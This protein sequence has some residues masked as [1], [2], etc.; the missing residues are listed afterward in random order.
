MKS[1]NIIVLLVTILITHTACSSGMNPVSGDV[2]SQQ[3]NNATQYLV[4]D[5]FGVSGSGF[6][7]SYCLNI[8]RNPLTAELEPLRSGYLGEA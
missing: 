8:D 7:G 3:L 4:L 2:N 6:L 5:T 1:R